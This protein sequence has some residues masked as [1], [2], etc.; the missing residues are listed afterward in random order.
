MSHDSPFYV[1]GATLRLLRM[2]NIERGWGEKY[3]NYPFAWNIYIFHASLQS[4]SL[5]LPLTFHCDFH[6]DL[7]YL[8][9]SYFHNWPSS[10]G[11]HVE[12][13]GHV[14]DSIYS[15]IGFMP[16]FVHICLATLLSC[17]L[18]MR[19]ASTSYNTLTSW[20]EFIFLFRFLHHIIN[21]HDP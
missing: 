13:W 14:Q 12:W 20:L 1:G 8:D 10:T 19:L 3:L 17:P 9:D 2:V 6:G 16:L 11:T 21:Y 4:S 5:L 18:K 15:W 7:L